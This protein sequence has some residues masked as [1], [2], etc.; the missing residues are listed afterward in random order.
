VLFFW[1]PGRI[2]PVRITRFSVEEQE[3][4]PLLYPIRA[5]VTLG[6]KI[7]D[8]VALQGDDSAIAKIAKACYTFTLAQKQALATANLANSVESIMGMLPF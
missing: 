7:L 8:A 6:V 2:V 5:T 3:F 1:G 4:S